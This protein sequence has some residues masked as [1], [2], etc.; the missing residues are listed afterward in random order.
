MKS[1]QHLSLNALDY[2][3]S[4]MAKEK[5]NRVI[6][7]RSFGFKCSSNFEKFKF[8]NFNDIKSNSLLY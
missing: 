6:S 5:G 7:E 1:V 8:C 3:I 4:E 2:D